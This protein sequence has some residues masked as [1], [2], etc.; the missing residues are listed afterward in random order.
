M[1]RKKPFIV[2]CQIK[3]RLSF[4][5]AVLCGFKLIVSVVFY[6]NKIGILCFAGIK[7]FFL[8]IQNAFFLRFGLFI[9]RSALL[10]APL[11]LLTVRIVARF[12][13]SPSKKES[14]NQ[15]NHKV[16]DN[17]CQYKSDKISHL[18]VTSSVSLI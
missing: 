2:K 1:E 10:I 6:F 4:S 13:A 9:V 12:S 11:L 14:K 16:D 18:K 5:A 17:D 15:L 3:N 7:T 8:K